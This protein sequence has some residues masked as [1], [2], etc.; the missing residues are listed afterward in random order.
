MS[1]SVITTTKPLAPD[2]IS[3]MLDI[4]E[5]F[6]AVRRGIYDFAVAN[7]DLAEDKGLETVFFVVS[8]VT[9]NFGIPPREELEIELPAVIIDMFTT[10]MVP[11]YQ[12]ILD[13]TEKAWTDMHTA[14]KA[15]NSTEE[16]LEAF[17]REAEPA[18]LALS[19]ADMLVMNT[20]RAELPSAGNNPATT[21]DLFA[22]AFGNK[23]A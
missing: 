14:L 17:L 11:A 6:H 13:P 3:T 2:V 4:N 12:H 7:P 20:A 1:T 19:G 10:E 22:D 5:R 16:L 15:G 9:R 8:S 21:T 18:V 23:R